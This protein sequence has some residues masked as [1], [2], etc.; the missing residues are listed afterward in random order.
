MRRALWNLGS[1]LPAPVR[2]LV[3]SAPGG[4]RLR[5]LAAGSPKGPTPASGTLRPV[6]YLPTWAQW[7][8]MRQRPQ[9]L[10]EAFAAAGHPVYFVDPREPKE[11]TVGAVTIV[12]SLQA[13]PGRHVILYLHFAPLRDLVG[14]FE[15]AV[16]VYDI[17]DDL[18]IYEADEVGLPAERTVAHHHPFLVER[19]DQVIVSNPILAERHA[20]ER[21]DL[22]LV[23]NGVDAE[24]FSTPAPRP[25]DLPDPGVPLIGYRGAVARWFDFDLLH[26]VAAVS[27]QWRF[28]I[29]G[30]VD[31]RVADEV[32]RVAALPNVT[33]LGERTSDEMPGYAQAFDAE[34]VW[35]LVDELTKGVTP[36]KVFESLA[37]GTP[38][39]STPL[40]ACETIPAVRTADGPQAFAETLRLALSDA[41]DPEW[42]STASAAAHA[43][44]WS[45]RLDPLL[46]RLDEAGRRMVP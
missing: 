10:L 7:D 21:P 1:R 44:D 3:K 11:R 42:R 40:P 9:F 18:T 15:D 24:Q 17:L 20:A 28:M 36:L 23:E 13:A 6:V 26:A 43:A 8:V 31:G 41:T 46:S 45:R 4:G 12:P 30:P 27:P 16:V 34:A 35:F 33:F 39:V 38:V 25:E 14:R 19:A 22:V 32:E 37:A 2:R 5:G 29:V